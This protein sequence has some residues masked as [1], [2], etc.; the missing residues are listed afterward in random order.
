MEC[1][2]FFKENENFL[3]MGASNSPAKVFRKIFGSNKDQNL[4]LEF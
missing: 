1:I 2:P 4:E 3:M